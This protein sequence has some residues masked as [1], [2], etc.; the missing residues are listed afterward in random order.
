[1]PAVSGGR[2]SLAAAFGLA[3]FA[4]IG[5]GNANAQGFCI[6]SAAAGADIP[7]P[8]GV[9]VVRSTNAVFTRPFK[10][11]SQKVCHGDESVVAQAFYSNLK[12]QGILAKR[13]GCNYRSTEFAADSWF[14]HLQENGYGRVIGFN[15][16]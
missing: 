5:A 11:A 1:M 10:V 9:G 14:R 3:A 8:G 6:C 4:L 15:Y 16:R 7:P 2:R 12:R 13:M